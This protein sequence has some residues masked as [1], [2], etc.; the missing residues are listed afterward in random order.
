MKKG[1]LL[2]LK[3]KRV[4]KR[5]IEYC[6]YR[7]TVHKGRNQ[8]KR[9]WS[10]LSILETLSICISLVLGVWLGLE[11]WNSEIHNPDI[12][13][14]CFP[15]ESWTITAKVGGASISFWFFFYS[16]YLN[17]SD[18]TLTYNTLCSSQQAY[19][20]ILIIYFTHSSPTSPVG[21]ISLFSIVKS[22]LLVNHFDVA[23]WKKLLQ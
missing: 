22:L 19:S 16:F 9:I 10:W 18:S 8:K 2:W 23:A 1:N 21:T 20:L 15:S 17:S 6:R 13:W 11:T 5:D 7:N 12:I 4:T 3:R 14:I